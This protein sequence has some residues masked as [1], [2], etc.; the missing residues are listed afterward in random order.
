MSIGV[1]R[2]PPFELGTMPDLLAAVALARVPE[3]T[4]PTA[5]APSSQ[6]RI[7][8]RMATKSLGQS[9]RCRAVRQV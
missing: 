1:L 7:I 6:A 9:G 8:G 4:G 3:I 2:Q 5:S